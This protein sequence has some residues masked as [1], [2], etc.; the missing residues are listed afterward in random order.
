MSDTAVDFGELDTA[1]VLEAWDIT[2]ILGTLGTA[3]V[4]EVLGGVVAILGTLGTGVVIEV[5]GV[6]ALLKGADG[7][8][9]LRALDTASILRL[10]DTANIPSGEIIKG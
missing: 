3:V 4:L 1:A 7:T 2:T 9:F 8:M 10:P 5:L 6:A